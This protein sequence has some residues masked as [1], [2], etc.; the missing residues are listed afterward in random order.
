MHILITGGTGLIGQALVTQLL[1]AHHHI[2]LLTRS[3]ARANQLFEYK[4]IEFIDDLHQ[5]NDLNHFDAVINLAGEPIF[6][7]RWTKQQK[8]RLFDSRVNLTKQL[9]KLIN[10]ST[11]KPQVFISSSA[12]G[13]YGDT[14]MQPTIETS[15]AG[16]GFPSQLCIAWE[17]AALQ[18]Q[19]RV[20]LL[21]T[22]M[23]LAGQGGA[24][25]KMLPAYRLGLG[26]KI[27]NGQQYWAWIHIQ[28]MVLSLI[29]I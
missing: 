16:N 3:I 24:L 17:Q 18:A 26:G 13:Y 29:H 7:R 10:Q 19:T 5:Y 27:G 22:S 15:S 4:T 8:Q 21:R 6:E 28:D 25:K 23:V 20:C 11:D 12:I 14:K 1:N 9:A 2:T